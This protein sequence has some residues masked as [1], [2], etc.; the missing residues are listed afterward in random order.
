MQHVFGGNGLFADAAFGKGQV[1]GNA[2]IQMVADHEHIDVFV[3]RVVRVRH[4]RV[5]GAG[6]KIRL[7]HHLQN[8]GCVP[9]AGPFGVEGAQ[10]ATFGGC[11]GVFY[12]AAFVQGVGVDGDLNVLLFGHIQAVANRCWGGAPVFVQLEADYACVNLLVQRIGQTRV[13]FAKKAQIHGEGIGRLQHAFDIPRAR[14]ASG[15]KR[16]RGRPRAAAH[17][18]GHSAGQGFFNLLRADE[19][20]V[21]INPACGDDIAFATDDLGAGANDDVHARLGIWVARFANTDN[22]PALQTNVGFHNTP[23]IQY[24]G[25]GHHTIDRALPT[26]ALALCH[27]VAYGFAA[28]KLHFLAVAACGQGE[29][30][31]DFNQQIRIRQAHTVAHGGAKDFRVGAALN[32]CH[33]V[34]LDHML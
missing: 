15:G 12:K 22:A 27:A 33:E 31:F 32:R 6:Q 9:A 5:G 2:R 26:G 1:F 17:H 11:D 7:P 23:V 28:A 24:E 25:I 21:A 13:A 10:R 34:L 18:G 8:V 19:M 29:I 20:D 30:L 4:G 3:E 16:A 14:C